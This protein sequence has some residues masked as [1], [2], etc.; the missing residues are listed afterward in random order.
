MRYTHH[1]IIGPTSGQT[2]C[3]WVRE[4]NYCVCVGGGGG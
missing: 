4:N 1:D 3:Q 2:P